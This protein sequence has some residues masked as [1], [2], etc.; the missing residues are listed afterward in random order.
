MMRSHSGHGERAG[1][2]E[3]VHTAAHGDHGEKTNTELDTQYP[4]LRGTRRMPNHTRYPLR[5]TRYPSLIG[6]HF[7]PRHSPWHEGKLRANPDS[8]W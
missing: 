4:A 1:T 8:G 6:W 3:E 2:A 7:L 5:V